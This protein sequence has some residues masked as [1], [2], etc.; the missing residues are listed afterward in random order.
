VRPVH[1][2]RAVQ[3]SDEARRYLRLVLFGAAVGIPAALAA[4]LFLAAVHYL[5]D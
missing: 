4:A 3:S 1:E 2:T 5:Q